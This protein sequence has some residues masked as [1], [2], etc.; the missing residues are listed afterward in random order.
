MAGEFLKVMQS[1]VTPIDLQLKSSLATQVAENKQKRFPIV[2]IVLFCGRH[3]IPLRGHH[4]GES[5]RSGAQSGHLHF[6]VFYMQKVE[7]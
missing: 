2:K 6:H 4:K 3:N 1:K 7:S 5:S